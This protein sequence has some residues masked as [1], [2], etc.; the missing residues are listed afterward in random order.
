MIVGGVKILSL[1]YVLILLANTVLAD[2]MEPA[3]AYSS[4]QIHGTRQMTITER[5]HIDGYDVARTLT[6]DRETFAVTRPN[7]DLRS[8]ILQYGQRLG[9]TVLLHAKL[10][11]YMAIIMFML[12]HSTPFGYLSPRDIRLR[13][14]CPLV[15]SV[16]MLSVDL[17]AGWQGLQL[18]PTFSYLDHFMVSLGCA[19]LIFGA[20][21]RN[22][23]LQL[24]GILAQL[25]GY[26]CHLNARWSLNK[27]RIYCVI[28]ALS[29]FDLLF[30]SLNIH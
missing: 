25:N 16:P 2:H 28:F 14:L 6:G 20:N 22:F 26:F 11:T 9:R 24:T 12:P 8:V 7:F 15:G 4:I 13:L 30:S 21:T 1:L 17:V 29:F 23:V 3:R 27:N 18:H 10:Y 19:Q 5:Y